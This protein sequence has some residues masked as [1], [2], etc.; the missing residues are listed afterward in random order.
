[1]ADSECLMGGLAVVIREHQLE[2]EAPEVLEI[3][4]LAA[5]AV[6]GMIEQSMELTL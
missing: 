3:E 6:V 4:E 5:V 2:A 1:M